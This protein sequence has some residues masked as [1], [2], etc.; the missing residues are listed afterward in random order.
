MLNQKEK[1][2]IMGEIEIVINN[3][4]CYLLVNK[5][6][7]DFLQDDLLNLMNEL[8]KLISFIQFKL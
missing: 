4:E 8:N 5:N 2:K 3:I 6:L 1:N 7:P